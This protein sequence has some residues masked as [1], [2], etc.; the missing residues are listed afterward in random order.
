MIQVFKENKAHRE[1]NTGYFLPKVEIKNYDAMIDGQ[2]F[3][4]QPV[5]IS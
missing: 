5:K 2:I 1:R 4:N 3:L